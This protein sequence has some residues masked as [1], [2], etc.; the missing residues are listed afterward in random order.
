MTVVISRLQLKTN[1]VIHSH[2]EARGRAAL[3]GS[4]RLRFLAPE[5][6]DFPSFLSHDGK[7]LFV[8]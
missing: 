5:K 6:V 3:P 1:F 8:S 2:D 4:I 7:L